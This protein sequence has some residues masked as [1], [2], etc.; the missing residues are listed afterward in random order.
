[1]DDGPRASLRVLSQ[2]TGVSF[3][4][5]QKIVKKDLHLFPYRLTC[6]QELFEVDYPRRVTF[7]RW[8]L[9][10]FYDNDLLDKTFFTDEA[11]FYLNGY[12]NSQNWR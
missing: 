8:F 12:V 1:M 10:N 7:C 5:C 9:Q 4:T 2:S 6:V 11:W 3:G